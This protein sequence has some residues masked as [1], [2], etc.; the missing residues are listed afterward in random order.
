MDANQ[1]LGTLLGGVLVPPRRRPVRRRTSAP[2]IDVRIGSSRR[3]ASVL[4]GLAGLAVEALTR[5]GQ[6]TVPQAPTASAPRGRPAAAPL[7]SPQP[8][9]TPPAGGT[10]TKSPWGERPPAPAPSL[11]VGAE[12][13]EVLLVIRAMIAASRADGAIDPEERAAIAS[14]LDSADL[15][16]EARDLVLSEFATP[17]TVESL[18]REITDPVLAAQVY[19]ACVLA[20]GEITP[21]ERSWLDRFA[22]LTR[23]SPQTCAAIEQR[24]SEG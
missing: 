12:D 17:A 11:P 20:V 21:P 3:T 9:P 4:A 6:S 24:L 8:A 10:G 13:R 14:Q 15:D 18:A 7:P 2:L 23:L 5:S 1:L 16:A 19:A 22:A